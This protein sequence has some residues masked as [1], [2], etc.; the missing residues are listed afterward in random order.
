VEAKNSVNV[1]FESKL[2]DSL[3]RLNGSPTELISTL[4]TEVSEF[5]DGKFDDDL[6]MFAIKRL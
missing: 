5:C 6:T 4:L 1:E 3:I 2:V